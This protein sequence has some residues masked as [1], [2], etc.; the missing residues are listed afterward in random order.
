MD[1][2]HAERTLKAIVDGVDAYAALAKRAGVDPLDLVEH[3][4]TLDRAIQLMKGFYK[5]GHE[6]M[7]P[8]GLPPPK[9]P[10][11]EPEAGIE[12]QS[13]EYFAYEA[14]QRG[15]A[16]RERCL[17]TCKQLGLDAASAEVAV[18]NVCMPWRTANGWRTYVREEAGGR[19]VLQDKPPVK[20]KR[21]L[22]HLLGQ[23]VDS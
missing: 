6:N 18:D 7:K 12:E 15:N 16:D 14:V 5:Y 4:D 21:H 9:N 13:A 22:A 11:Y 1:R 23:L 8:A 2:I 20:L 3:E 19:Y 17:F 10:Y